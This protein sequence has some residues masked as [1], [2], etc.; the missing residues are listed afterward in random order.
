MRFRLLC[1]NY[2]KVEIT[3]FEFSEGGVY[4]F[5]NSQ[6]VEITVFNSQDI[7][8]TNVRSFQLL[9]DKLFR[10]DNKVFTHSCILDF[11]MMVV[12]I[13]DNK[14]KKQCEFCLFFMI[15]IFTIQGCQWFSWSG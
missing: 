6:K 10:G 15:N 4:N 12:M 5:L 8:I 13:D 14:T 7:E 3:N 9:E 1:F 11:K 2:Q